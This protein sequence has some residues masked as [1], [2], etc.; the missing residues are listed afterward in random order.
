VCL[1]KHDIADVLNVVQVLVFHELDDV[2]DE[3][4]LDPDEDKAVFHDFGWDQQFVE[5]FDAYRGSLFALVSALVGG[6]HVPRRIDQDSLHVVSTLFKVQVLNSLLLRALHDFS[7][8]LR[9]Q[10]FGNLRFDFCFPGHD[11]VEDRC[12][13]WHKAF[14][15]VLGLRVVLLLGKEL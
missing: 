2:V 6:N 10:I 15:I 13:G 1:V 3:F 8:L 9:D 5:V 7:K 14:S 11:Q 4:L 12:V